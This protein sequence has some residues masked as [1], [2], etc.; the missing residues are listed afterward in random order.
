MKDLVIV[1]R[2]M[3]DADISAIANR[4]RAGAGAA[5]LDDF[6]TALDLALINIGCLPENGSLRYA[7]ELGIAKLRTWPVGRLPYLLFY[8]E[9]PTHIDL[10]RVLHKQRDIPARLRVPTRP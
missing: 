10:W 8:I 2:K 1:P 6:I 3:A 5:A 4:Y 9:R 7:E